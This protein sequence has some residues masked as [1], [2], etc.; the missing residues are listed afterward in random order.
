MLLTLLSAGQFLI[1]FLAPDTTAGFP[2]ENLAK[3][4][5]PKEDHERK[6]NSS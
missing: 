6:L 4:P 2:D 3:L 5:S 1:L